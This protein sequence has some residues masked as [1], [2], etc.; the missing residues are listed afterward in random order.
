[1]QYAL[2]SIHLVICIYDIAGGLVDGHLSFMQ[3][4]DFDHVRSGVPLVLLVGVIVNCLLQYLNNKLL[5]I[6]MAEF[7]FLT[8]KTASRASKGH[9]GQYAA[10]PAE[11]KY[12]ML[13]AC[14]P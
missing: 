7:L 14:T 13:A 2:P 6:A 1:M 3:L 8:L 5:G 9:A 11:W 10:C 12:R 4:P